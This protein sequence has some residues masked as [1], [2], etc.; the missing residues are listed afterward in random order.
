MLRSGNGSPLPSGLM[1]QIAEALPNLPAE[2]P[3]SVTVTVTY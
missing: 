1:S 3:D 2:H